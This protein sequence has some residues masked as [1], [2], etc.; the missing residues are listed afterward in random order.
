MPRPRRKTGKKSRVR[1]ARRAGRPKKSVYP[2]N[3]DWFGETPSGKAVGMRRRRKKMSNFGGKP[4][5]YPSKPYKP[6]GK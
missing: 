5:R 2:E 4:K 6:K 1:Q 3:P